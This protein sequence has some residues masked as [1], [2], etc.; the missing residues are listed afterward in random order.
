MNA[1]STSRNIAD[2]NQLNSS[3]ERIQNVMSSFKRISTIDPYKPTKKRQT[4]LT[5]FIFSIQEL[6]STLDK[7]DVSDRGKSISNSLQELNKFIESGVSFHKKNTKEHESSLFGSVITSIVAVVG[8]YHILDG[9]VKGIFPSIAKSFLPS[10]YKITGET[11]KDF[12]NLIK[13]VESQ[14]EGYLASYNKWYGGE[15]VTTLTIKEVL[16]AQEKGLRENKRTMITSGPNK[17]KRSSAIGLYQITSTT[18]K[19]LVDQGVVSESD[20]F[21]PETQDKLGWYLLVRAGFYE[22]AADKLDVYTFIKNLRSTWE[23]L[24]NISDTELIN[25]LNDLKQKHLN[26]IE[27]KY[28]EPS[29]FLLESV[30]DV[31][32]YIEFGTNTGSKENYLKLDPKLRDSIN[33]LAKYYYINYGSKLK[34]ESAH[35]SEEENIAVGG[36]TKSR[37]LKGL[38]VDIPEKQVLE[39]KDVLHQFGLESIG[40]EKKW[41]EEIHHIQFRKNLRAD[42]NKREYGDGLYD[43]SYTLPPNSNI[44]TYT[45]HIKRPTRQTIIYKN[46]TEKNIIRKY[47]P[48]TQKFPLTKKIMV[49]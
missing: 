24:N 2:F 3:F 22:F 28:P 18:L 33:S 27:R 37:H 25:F 40:I 45:E 13:S 30:K 1:L 10:E 4:V 41:K 49:G 48:P 29:T 47:Y 14:E 43:E 12:A 9:V 34:I 19:D 23:G 17:G 5:K 15:D 36:S 38:A 16:E 39:L 6:G 32:K 26:L 35:R 21:T 46:D 8:I 11:K 20:I 44:I 42:V 31:E 7:E